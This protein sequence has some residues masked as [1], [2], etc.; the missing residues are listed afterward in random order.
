MLDFL[1]TIVTA[2]LMTL[3]VNALITYLEV[4]RSAKLAL[5]GVAGL[6]IG[7]AAAASASGWLSISHPFAIIGVFVATPLLAAA[8]AIL[9]SAARAALLGLPTRLMIGLNIGRVFAVLFLLLATQG[10]LAG[11][12]PFFAGCG[13]IITG[14]AAVPLLFAAVDGKHGSAIVESFWR[15]RSCARNFPRGDLGGRLAGAA[16]LFVARLGCNKHLPW[17]FVPT[18]LVPLYLIMH[19]TIWTQLRAQRART[20]SSIST[21]PR[22]A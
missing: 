21:T 19:A 14:A 8:I 5:A 18:V 16:F 13:D 12:F 9:W 1:G 6:W 3:I 22:T 4:R 7:L 15:G 2:A 17:A 20:R 11:P 10:R